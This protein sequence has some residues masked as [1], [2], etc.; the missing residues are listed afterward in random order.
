[1]ITDNDDYFL[2]FS[3]GFVYKSN[4]TSLRLLHVDSC[5]FYVLQFFK[6]F[7]FW[8]VGMFT[9]FAY[10]IELNALLVFFYY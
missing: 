7:D 10:C 2:S 6:F 1:M 3:W 8:E 9:S 5:R 4:E